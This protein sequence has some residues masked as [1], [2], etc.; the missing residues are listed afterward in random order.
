MNIEPPDGP[1]KITVESRT[2]MD[3]L[4]ERAVH[5]LKNKAQP[6]KDRG[7]LITRHSAQDF[8]V[9]L[10]ASVPFGLTQEKQEW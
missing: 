5:L 4:L 3:F 8:T 10:H 9:E 7:I 6:M 1:F 2:D